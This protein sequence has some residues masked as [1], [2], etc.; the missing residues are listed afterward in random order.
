MKEEQNI[1]WLERFRSEINKFMIT[2]HKNQ[3]EIGA[4]LGITRTS[5]N[6]LIG[7]KTAPDIHK[8]ELYANLFEIDMNYVFTGIKAE[9][10]PNDVEEMKKSISDLR[11]MVSQIYL[12]LN[13]NR[14]V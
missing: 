7:G 11:F 3:N 4:M 9:K 10:I 6:R 5:V 12:K 13:E 2:H 8:L 1:L 14:S